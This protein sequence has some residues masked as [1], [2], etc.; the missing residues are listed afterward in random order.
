MDTCV[1]ELLNCN[2]SCGIIVG[3]S[4]HSTGRI[5]K[6]E[7]WIWFFSWYICFLQIWILLFPAQWYKSIY[8]SSI[9]TVNKVNQRRGWVSP[10]NLYCSHYLS[11]QCM[12]VYLHI[13]IVTYMT[14]MKITNLRNVNIKYL[15]L[16]QHSH[17]LKLCFSLYNVT[18]LFVS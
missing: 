7:Y 3:W 1:R 18:V 12:C 5:I 8:Q 11:R 10:L 17:F 4:C 9:T 13:Y 2:F 14:H 6:Y 15:H 16:D